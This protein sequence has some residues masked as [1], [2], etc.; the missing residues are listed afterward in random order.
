MR[1]KGFTLLELLVTL[2]IAALVL[3]VV[4]SRSSV[5][6]N[7]SQYAQA[8]RDVNTLLKTSK[9]TAL[10]TGSDV[11]VSFDPDAR[12]LSFGN[13]PRQRVELPAFVQLRAEPD[14]NPL[15]VFRAD[16]TAYGGLLTILYGS[17]GVAFRLNWALGFV[18]QTEVSSPK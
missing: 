4:S 6:L 15:F 1:L 10:Q 16:G 14:T 2:A 13:G 17:S 7:R 5:I 18:E 3:S 8:L 12:T 11:H 9:A